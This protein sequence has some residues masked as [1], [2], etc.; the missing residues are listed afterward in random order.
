MRVTTQGGE[1]HATRRVAGLLSTAVLLASFTGCFIRRGGGGL[2]N[3]ER[4]YEAVFRLETAG[5]FTTVASHRRARIEASWSLDK[6]IPTT[7]ILL[8]LDHWLKGTGDKLT[9]VTTLITGFKGDGTYTIPAMDAPR[10]PNDQGLMGL[11]ML[12][13]DEKTGALR[14]YEQPKRPCTLKVADFGK[15][16]DI[17][18]PELLRRLEEPIS[19]KVRWRGTKSYPLPTP[20]QGVERRTPSPEEEVPPPE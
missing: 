2:S 13:K 7:Y 6:Q 12:L 16:V 19:L 8:H 3:D 20:E 1:M 4:G 14:L 18:C 5:T 15:N 11:R 10:G 9:R 17:K